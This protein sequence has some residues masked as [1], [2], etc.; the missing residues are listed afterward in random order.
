ME[1][2][3]IEIN[4]G[5]FGP[6][7]S[8]KSTLINC[9]TKSQLSNTGSN[10]TTYIPQVYVEDCNNNFSYEIINQININ[11]TM[12]YLAYPQI[13]K[14]TVFN[15]IFHKTTGFW[16]FLS[17]NL[18]ETAV[19]TV[20]DN[21]ISQHISDEFIYRV[22]PMIKLNIWDMPGFDDTVDNDIYIKWLNSN[23]DIFDII[24]YV[25]DIN[26]C[27]DKFTTFNF[28]KQLIS[29][30]DFK[31]ICLINKCDEMYFDPEIGKFSFD[32]I[33]DQDIYLKIN[34]LVAQNISDI[35]LKNYTITPF[36]PLTL[37]N[38]ESSNR[39]IDNFRHIL[40]NILISNI[41]T[42]TS[43]HL[44]KCLDN[45]KNMSDIMRFLR[46]ISK[47]ENVQFKDRN[48]DLVWKKIS[49]I[50][51][52]HEYNIIRKSITLCEK[53]INYDDFDRIH[54]EI[55]EYLTF[56]TSINV[57]EK[58]PEYPTDLLKYHKTKL[59]S[60]LL[61]IYDELCNSEYRGQPHICPSNL[62]VFLELIKT[63]VPQEFDKYAIKFIN[64][65]KDVKN[66]TKSYEKNLI[67]MIEYTK[68][69]VSKNYNMNEYLAPICQIIINKQ[70][71]IKNKLPNEYF[72]YLIELKKLIKQIIKKEIIIKLNPLDILLEVIKKNISNYLSDSGFTNLYRPELNTVNIDKSF[73][74]FINNDKIIDLDF[75]KNLLTFNV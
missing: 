12:K 14:S 25:T 27:L 5:I 9:M 54:S 1:I 3:R 59:I 70:Q 7:C 23:I 66:F 65:H 33:D 47:F 13:L 45:I 15:P 10:K 29:K 8:G 67:I 16:D 43:K 60:N 39:C 4:I 44:V 41:S 58:W 30:Y 21:E 73:N 62:L 53:K 19:E 68:L 69:N 64:I 2:D 50:L 40:F 71:F 36:I 37:L 20:N 52:A 18:V 72:I 6:S 17:N 28:L 51:I 35:N 42:F 48:T 22:K 31:M 49:N 34:N 24:I 75:E 32:N 61:N 38:N 55:Q 74:Y 56:F 63:H 26:Q 57:L 46:V 11:E